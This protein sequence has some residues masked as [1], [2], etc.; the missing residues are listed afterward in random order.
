MLKFHDWSEKP[1]VQ[2][3]LV[4]F[5]SFCGPCVGVDLRAFNQRLSDSLEGV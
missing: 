1:Q 3:R 4:M 5:N 2:W